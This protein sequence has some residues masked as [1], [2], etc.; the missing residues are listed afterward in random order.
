MVGQILEGVVEKLLNN[1]GVKPL[2]WSKQWAHFGVVE[3]WL[4][5][6]RSRRVLQIEQEC[7]R[8]EA[9][10]IK[11][12]PP[13]CSKRS[14]WNRLIYHSNLPTQQNFSLTL[15]AT[16]QD[17][18]PEIRARI[19][20]LEVG[21][22]GDIVPQTRQ[23]LSK[24]VSKNVV[25]SDG[26]RK[27]QQQPKALCAENEKEQKNGTELL[28]DWCVI[29]EDR[30][31]SYC[32]HPSYQDGSC[33]C[34]LP[35]WCRM[36]KLNRLA[37]KALKLGGSQRQKTLSAVEWSRTRL[38]E[39]KTSFFI[40]IMIEVTYGSSCRWILKNSRRSSER[41]REEI[42]VLH[43]SSFLSAKDNQ[44]PWYTW[45]S[46][47]TLSQ[48]NIDDF[49]ISADSAYK[50]AFLLKHFRYCQKVHWSVKGRGWAVLIFGSSDKWSPGIVY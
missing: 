37:L 25:A 33:L 38:C 43:L 26:R 49:F 6:Y 40:K 3:R 41:R 32:Y 47:L 30:R 35:G 18:L 15:R 39:R 21:D 45:H 36:Q 2:L 19:G 4:G 17:N 14:D 10:H 1:H 22:E 31:V 24:R 12:I 48:Y 23:A 7:V 50:Q 5:K 44:C 27:H 16:I 20:I 29:V 13:D 8:G 42:A 9:L 34:Q 28:H 46:T 11:H